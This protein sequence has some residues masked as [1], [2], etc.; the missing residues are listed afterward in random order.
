MRQQDRPVGCLKQSHQGVVGRC[1]H[2][3]ARCD[4]PQRKDSRSTSG[5]AWRH[6]LSTP[7]SARASSAQ[8]G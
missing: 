2:T 7:A 5:A 8:T 4:V 1:S 6:A 3:A